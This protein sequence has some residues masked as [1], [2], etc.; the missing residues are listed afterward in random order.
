MV[1]FS[2]VL[3]RD[4]HENDVLSIK[5][6][7]RKPLIDHVRPLLLARLVINGRS[8]DAGQR[9][10]VQLHGGSVATDDDGSVVTVNWSSPAQLF[11]VS[12]KNSQILIRAKFHYATWF[13][14][15]SK[16]VADRSATS[17][18]PVCDQRRT[19]FEPASN[20]IA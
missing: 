3:M 6:P 15:G 19:C 12:E 20:Q 2:M 18:E 8:V 17:F 13:E 1:S 4:G 7:G 10:V 11:A 9:T 5:C 14:G 16:L